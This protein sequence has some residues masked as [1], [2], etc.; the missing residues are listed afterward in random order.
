MAVEKKT[1][2]SIKKETIKAKVVPVKTKKV[3]ASRPAAKTV[4]AVKPAKHVRVRTAEGL[5][6]AMMKAKAKTKS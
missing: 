6:R 3:E 4:V 5:K 1:T 2:K